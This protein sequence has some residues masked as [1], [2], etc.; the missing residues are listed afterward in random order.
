MGG[1]RAHNLSHRDRLATRA[2][3]PD[4]DGIAWAAFIRRVRNG[5]LDCPYPRQST[6]R[7][8]DQTATVTAIVVAIPFIFPN[9]NN[10][11]SNSLSRGAPTRTKA[12]RIR[13]PRAGA[14]T[15]GYCERL[16]G[17]LSVRRESH[18]ESNTTGGGSGE[19][20][21]VKQR[22]LD[23]AWSHGLRREGCAHVEEY[24]RNNERF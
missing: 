5:P 21:A 20:L 6:Y 9:W 12:L 10:R 16:T 3:E 22:R 7:Y 2:T 18:F 15:A 13:L 19:G 8:L 23:V 4:C 11:E 1:V 24:C 17:H 14:L